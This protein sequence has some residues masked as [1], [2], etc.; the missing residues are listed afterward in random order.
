MKHLALFI[1]ILVLAVLACGPSG[2]E[3][4]VEPTVEAVAPA[5]QAAVPGVGETPAAPGGSTTTGGAITD[6]STLQQ[7]VIQI[8]AEGTFVDPE[9][10]LQVN[11]AGRGTGFIIDPSGIAAGS[12]D[13][14]SG[15][16]VAVV[17]YSTPQEAY[18]QELEPL[19]RFLAEAGVL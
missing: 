5:T 15:G 16:E 11:S 14:E 6:L 1:S 13:G 10:G 18:E 9:F 3:P 12:G 8:Q 7:A 17:A 19:R 2:G 4:E